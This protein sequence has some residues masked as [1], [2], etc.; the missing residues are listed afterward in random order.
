MLG[1]GLC[2]T[3]LLTPRSSLLA[4][5]IIW[6]CRQEIKPQSFP[7]REKTEVFHLQLNITGFHRRHRHHHRHRSWH[8]EFLHGALLK[9]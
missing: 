7:D 2:V 6:V 3:S 1:A 9:G 5:A 8:R 4:F